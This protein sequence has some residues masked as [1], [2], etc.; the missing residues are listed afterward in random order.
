MIGD[1]EK[2]PLQIEIDNNH[3]F[4]FRRAIYPS[5]D[6]EKG[7]VISKSDI[8]CLG[9]IKVFVLQILIYLLGKEAKLKFI[10]IKN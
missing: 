9:L 3:R 10:K 1:N 7:A 8:H 4:S 2:V 6:I 5:K